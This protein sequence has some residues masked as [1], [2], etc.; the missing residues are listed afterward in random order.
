LVGVDVYPIELLIHPISLMLTLGC[1]WF[2]ASFEYLL[3]L[4]ER[5]QEGSMIAQIFG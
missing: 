2:S 5:I 1:Q 4:W 3:R